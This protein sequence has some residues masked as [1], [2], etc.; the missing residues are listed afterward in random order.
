MMAVVGRRACAMG[1]MCSAALHGV[2][3]GRVTSAPAAVLMAA[4]IVG[5]LYC[6]RDLWMD[7]TLRGWTL[8][9]VMN[10]VMIGVH[11]PASG[12]HHGAGSAAS[13]VAP[14]ST[15]MTLASA[16]A[17]TEALV[18]TAVLVYRT[19]RTRMFSDEGPTVRSA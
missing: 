17:A 19:R 18:A 5:C 16:F 1:A 10:L 11:L 12:H 4:M 14:E 2:S 8:V 6:A 13:A 9:A 3:L 15:A 7:D